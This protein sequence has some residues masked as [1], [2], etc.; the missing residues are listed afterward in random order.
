MIERKQSDWKSRAERKTTSTTGMV[1]RSDGSWMRVQMTDL[2]YD[3]CHLLTEDNLN[4]GETLELVI[5][6]M[7][8][9]NVQVRWIRENE[10]GVRLLRHTSV[11]DERRARL[12]F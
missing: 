6:H 3:G 2:S 9:L 12:G 11:A 4:V 1:Y 8:H 10:A 5:P 7:Q